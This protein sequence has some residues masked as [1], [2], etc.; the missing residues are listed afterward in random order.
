MHGISFKR[1]T[2]KKKKERKIMSITVS[3]SIM[4]ERLFQPQPQAKVAERKKSTVLNKIP[5]VGKLC[6]LL[7][8]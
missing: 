6:S 4:M 3:L 2:H 5:V 1:Y 7:Q 8:K